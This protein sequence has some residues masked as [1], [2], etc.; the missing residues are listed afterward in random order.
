MKNNVRQ[1]VIR[2]WSSNNNECPLNTESG[3]SDRSNHRKL[4][5]IKKTVIEPY[6]KFTKRFFQKRMMSDPAIS[7][8]PVPKPVIP[9]RMAT[10]TVLKVVVTAAVS[11]C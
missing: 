6:L 4:I 9:S 2:S 1:S 7:L 8:V 11:V 5:D 10:V 3:R